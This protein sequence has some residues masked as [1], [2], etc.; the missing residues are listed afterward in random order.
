LNKTK[1]LN[2][3]RLG[4]I[5]GLLATTLA[6]VINFILLSPPPPYN[7]SLD[8]ITTFLEQE[9]EMI[10]LSTGLRYIVWPL[11]LIFAVGLYQFIRGDEDGNHRS[12]AKI[13]I[14]GIVWMCSMG[15]VANSAEIIAAWRIE[16][17]GTQPQLLTGL[18]SISI[19]LFTSAMV[20]WATAILSFS[21]AGRLSGVLPVWIAGLGLVMAILGLLTGIGIVSA[22]TG[23]WAEI[24]SFSA[25][26]LVNIWVLAVS[27]LMLRN[28]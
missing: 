8:V 12:W 17:L 20:P 10:V 1:A 25:F 22:V 9:V 19:V 3:V 28:S 11:G 4:G 26:V 14:L 27:V 16:T 23:G 7:S 5:A 13:G 15:A 2:F 6:I 21:I 18:W 24:P